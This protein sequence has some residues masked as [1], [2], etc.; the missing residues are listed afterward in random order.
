MAI[1]SK[2][3]KMT[4]EIS[5][6]RYTVVA[7]SKTSFG[8]VLKGEPM[9]TPAVEICEKIVDLLEQLP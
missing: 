2:Q 6:D 4:V 3:E 1:L 5:C 9:K 7:H 8:I